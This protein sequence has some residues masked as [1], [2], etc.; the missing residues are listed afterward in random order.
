MKTKVQFGLLELMYWTAVGGALLGLLLR[1]LDVVSSVCLVG[2]W[3]LGTIAV[4]RYRGGEFAVVYSMGCGTCVMG[5]FFVRHSGLIGVTGLDM[6][7]FVASAAT[8][9]SLSTVAGPMMAGI[10]VVLSWIGKRIGRIS[11]RPVPTDA[12]N[13]SNSSAGQTPD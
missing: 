8:A 7:A 11:Q 5:L 9:G 4:L 3:L 6:F 12:S 13:E 10:A 2:P 1:I